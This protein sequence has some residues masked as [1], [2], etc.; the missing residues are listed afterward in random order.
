MKD[1]D[2]FSQ[3]IEMI[4]RFEYVSNKGNTIHPTENDQKLMRIVY[5]LTVNNDSYKNV[6]KKLHSIP[7]K[8]RYNYIDNY[9]NKGN[10][11]ISKDESISFGDKL[12]EKPE[13][14]KEQ[15]SFQFV[16]KNRDGF[17]DNVLYFSIASSVLLFLA[18]IIA[19]FY[20]YIS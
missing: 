17:V 15:K 19:L 16:K 18:L 14:K 1:R 9:F 10:E 5:S 20:Y 7:P 6:L 3:Y 11:V 4:N 2:I 8:E 13:Q 12:E